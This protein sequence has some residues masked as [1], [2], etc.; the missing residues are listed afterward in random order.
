MRFSLLRDIPNKDVLRE[1][2]RRRRAIVNEVISPSQPFNC[3]PHIGLD[4]DTRIWHAGST[5]RQASG[6]CANLNYTNWY[7]GPPDRPDFP[8]LFRQNF[9]P[10]LASSASH[11]DDAQEFLRALQESVDVLPNPHLKTRVK[12]AVSSVSA[13]WQTAKRV[14]Q[15]KEEAEARSQRSLKVLGTLAEAVGHD[16]FNIPPLM[17]G[18]IRSFEKLLF[19]I[20]AAM[21]RPMERGWISRLFRLNRHRDGFNDFDKRLSDVQQKFEEACSQRSGFD[22]P[23]VSAGALTAPPD[24]HSRTLESKLFRRHFRFSGLKS[25]LDR[26]SSTCVDVA[27]TTLK[28]LEKPGSSVPILN[29]VVSGVSALL[30]TAKVEQYILLRSEVLFLTNC[31]ITL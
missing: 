31:S 1:E 3:L 21:E 20:R 30:D 17:L 4:G 25:R 15:S 23:F 2:P 16:P 8:F 18:D 22:T 27:S 29:G 10:D 12:S 9:H 28:V 5:Q 19:E 26:V 13:L 14:E 11:V 6:S 24:P 7:R